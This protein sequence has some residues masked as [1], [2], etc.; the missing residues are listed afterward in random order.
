MVRP[1]EAPATNTVA[2]PSEATLAYKN[3]NVY[4]NCIIVYYCI[5]V[6]EY[7]FYH[8]Y[9]VL[10]TILNNSHI[11]LLHMPGLMIVFCFR[12]E[13]TSTDK[14]VPRPYVCMYVHK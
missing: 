4:Y 12:H 11:V 9:K 1:L 3:T 8:N 6:Q 5:I 13:V 14:V 7:K 2:I 10:Y